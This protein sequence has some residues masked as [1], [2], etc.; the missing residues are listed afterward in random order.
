M[1][2]DE[3][4]EIQKND[5]MMEEIMGE[6]REEKLYFDSDADFNKAQKKLKKKAKKSKVVEEEE[7]EEEEP[8]KV[9]KKKKI[10]K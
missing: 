6:L 4:A 1:G 3:E 10:K 5:E 7:V 8:V 2:K 9:A